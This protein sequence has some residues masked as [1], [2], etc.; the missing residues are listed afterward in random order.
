M[1][2]LTPANSLA[3]GTARRDSLSLRLQKRT[4]LVPFCTV[5]YL[6]R[7]IEIAGTQRGY[8]TTDDARELDV[9]P[10]ELRKLASRGL[11]EHISHGLYRIEA[12]P[13]QEHDDLMQAVLW[14]KGRGV[15]SH[16]TALVLWE[17]ADVHPKMI[18]VSVPTGYR[19]RRN[20]G[21]RYRIVNRDLVDIEYVAGIPVVTPEQAIR[22]A[23]EDGTQSRFIQQAIHNARRRRLIGPT[24]EQ[25]L[26]KLL[27]EVGSGR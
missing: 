17:L 10:V 19:P 15:I 5:T 14:P 21:A 1:A 22:D 4:V 13:H 18:T 8:V 2:A 27:T 24:T 7:L 3:P 16:E 12:F 23:I 20:N 25:E 9:P 6:Q 26:L 11:L